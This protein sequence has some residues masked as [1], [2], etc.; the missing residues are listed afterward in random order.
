LRYY[1]ACNE[2][3]G[4]SKKLYSDKL[5]STIPFS[6]DCKTADNLMRQ[7]FDAGADDFLTKPFKT[8]ELLKRSS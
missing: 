2:W 3:T 4:F 7:C 1:D 5:L 6:F 8:T